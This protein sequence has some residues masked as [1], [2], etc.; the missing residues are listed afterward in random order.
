MHHE[1]EGLP[2]G[3]ADLAGRSILITGGAGAIGGRLAGLLAPH[4]EVTVLDD[5]SSSTL[6][7]VPA[8]V[9]FVN[10]SILE[11]RALR[12]AL[13]DRTDLVFHLA[14][15]FANQNSV[16]HPEQDLM[17]NGL[18]T[19][20]VL[21][22]ALDAGVAS[23]VYASSSC[24]YGSQ[25]GELS[26]HLAPGHLDTPYAIT[27][28][29]GELYARY[30]SD[31][32][33]RQQARLVGVRYF[34]VYGPGELPGPYR[35]VIPNFIA[36]AIEGRPLRITGTGD[37]TRDFTFVDDAARG[38]M[39]AATAG[40]SGSIYNLGTGQP[41]AIADLARSIVDA[42]GSESPICY[43]ERRHWDSIAHRRA[44]LELSRG[45]LGY[46]PRVPFEEGIKET[47]RWHLD[48]IGRPTC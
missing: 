42:T 36:S 31:Q 44:D 4:A 22:T 29:L 37:E 39:L 15:L 40:K 10:G 25:A 26:E 32:A 16:E 30:Y 27:K 9:R 12:E 11:P 1:S 6:D 5:L 8:E 46:T 20:R 13:G 43:G 35:N 48:R 14:A 24:V 33:E 41:T 45:E 17:V 28:H 7:Q 47:V 2:D 18:G 19:L 3:C 34:N 21:E 38:T 23:I